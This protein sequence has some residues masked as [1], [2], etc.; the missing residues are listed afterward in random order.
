MYDPY[1]LNFTPFKLNY[2]LLATAG[3]FS[4]N[5]NIYKILKFKSK[6]EKTSLEINPGLPLV[7]HIQHIWQ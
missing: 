1:L 5:C 3:K 6:S 4:V 7:L 2:P